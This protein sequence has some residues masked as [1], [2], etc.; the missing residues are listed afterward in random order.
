MRSS[1]LER[2]AAKLADAFHAAEHE[3]RDYDERVR[4]IEAETTRETEKA[5]ASLGLGELSADAFEKVE[6]HSREQVEQVRAARARASSIVEALRPRAADAAEAVARE[7]V[8]AAEADEQRRAAAIEEAE[9]T[10]VK[11]RGEHALAAERLDVVR[12]AAFDARAPFDRLT[13][14]QAAARAESDEQ[15]A[16]WHARNPAADDRIP[17]HLRERVP[18]I[19]AAEAD[20]EEHERARLREHPERVD[21]A[22]VYSGR[23][24]RPRER[25]PRLGEL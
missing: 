10:L 16:R 7:K 15:L 11:L 5:A 23:S 4:S 22:D 3:Q 12:R 1:K 24:L 25:F 13:A 21:P 17:A 8:D 20:R 18:E 14:E 9:A 6:A 2:E 19:R